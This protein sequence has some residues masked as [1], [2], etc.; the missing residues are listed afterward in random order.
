MWFILHV[1]LAIYIICSGIKLM[2]TIVIKKLSLRF[3]K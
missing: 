2:R 3:K 1:S